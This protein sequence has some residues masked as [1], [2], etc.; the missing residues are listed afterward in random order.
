MTCRSA[1]A[2]YYYVQVKQC[3]SKKLEDFNQPKM[4]FARLLLRLNLSRKKCL[5]VIEIKL[6]Q[7]IE[8]CC[9]YA[10]MYI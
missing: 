9:K 8:I 3:Q 7:L 2:K 10:K 1:K 6:H 4:D 5:K